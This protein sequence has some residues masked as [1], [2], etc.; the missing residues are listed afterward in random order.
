MKLPDWLIGAVLFALAMIVLWHVRTFPD[1]P[2]QQYGAALFPGLAAAGLGI[3]ALGLMVT[4][5]LHRGRAAPRRSDPLG[6]IEAQAQA[7]ATREA[8]GAGPMTGRR[9]LALLL[10]V[11]SIVFYIVAAES[12]GFILTGILILVAMMGAYGSRPALIVPV[13]IVATLLVHTGF[14]KLLRVP[15]PW[16]VLQPIAW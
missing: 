3:A 4:G 1:I 12:L 6:E 8:G 11:G 5:L 2:G 16:G 13:A 7:E 9:W 15:L 14:Y 10:S